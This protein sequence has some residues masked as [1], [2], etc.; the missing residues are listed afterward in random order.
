MYMIRR[1]SDKMIAMF[2][3]SSND[4]AEF[5]T[6]TEFKLTFQQ[7]ADVA[8]VYQTVEAVNEAIWAN[9]KWYNATHYTPGWES[10][11]EAAMQA[12]NVEIVKITAM[13]AI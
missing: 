2:D 12:D 6:S 1:K 7:Y 4:G 8:A 10:D 11:F 3:I 13:E 9:S 5:A